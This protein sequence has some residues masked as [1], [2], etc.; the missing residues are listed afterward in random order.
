VRLLL[1]AHAVLWSVA[2]PSK[3]SPD[4][5][6]AIVEPENWVGVSAATVWEIEVKRASGRLRAPKDLLHA[7]RE[8]G[9]ETVP[10]S[11]EHAVQAAALPPIH[12]DP[13]D[14]M[15]VAQ[16]RAEGFTIVT[17]DDDVA[18]YAVQVIRA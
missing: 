15:I 12:S 18:Q 9:F 11:A 10:V 14:R 4:A 17:R 1:D 2:S 8:T 5:R 6:A 3:L 16:A 13:F 7:L